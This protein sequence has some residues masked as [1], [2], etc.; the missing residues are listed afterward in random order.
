VVIAA[1][2]K[3]R[4]IERELKLRRRLYPHWIEIGKIEAGDAKRQI[5]ILVEIADDYE[6]QAQSER[7][8]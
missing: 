1:E 8:L 3:L 4:E 2:D 6:K 5:D 7:L